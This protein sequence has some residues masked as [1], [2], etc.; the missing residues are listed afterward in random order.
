MTSGQLGLCLTLS[1]RDV[2]YSLEAHFVNRICQ[3]ALSK[4]EK[5]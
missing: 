5:R 2:G 1:L 4:G 3:H